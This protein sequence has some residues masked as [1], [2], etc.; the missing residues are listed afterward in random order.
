M[1][2][3]NLL[4]AQPFSLIQPVLGWVAEISLGIYSLTGV[5]ISPEVLLLL[6]I[7]GTGLLALGSLLAHQED[8]H[9]SYPERWK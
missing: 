2:L 3:A 9:T 5:L 8:A 4:V 6:A 7:F 1:M